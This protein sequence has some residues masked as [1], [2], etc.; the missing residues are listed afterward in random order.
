MEQR[1]YTRIPF[2]RRAR[3]VWGNQTEEVCC[4]ELSLCGLLLS[5]PEQ[6]LPWQPQQTFQLFLCLGEQHWIEMQCR[7][8]HASDEVFGCQIE[9]LGVA[10]LALLFRVL[11]FNLP[12][13]QQEL[14]QRIAVSHRVNP[15]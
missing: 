4:L 6:P 15:C 10:D 13:L 3:V 1:Q 9:H 7:L 2:V 12:S 8:V 11:S 14:R 5:Q